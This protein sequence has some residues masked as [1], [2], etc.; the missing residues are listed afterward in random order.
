LGS[1]PWEIAIGKVPNTILN[2]RNGT[3][4]LM[5]PEFFLADIERKLLH[6]ISM[7]GLTILYK[8]LDFNGL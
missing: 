3:D 2:T 8:N 1:R 4:G 7:K 5:S 6:L